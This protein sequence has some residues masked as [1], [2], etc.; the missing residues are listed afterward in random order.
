MIK[1]TY[2][3]TRKNVAKVFLGILTTCAVLT[4]FA[5]PIDSHTT[6]GNDEPTT[7]ME[8]VECSH[9]PETGIIT[10]IAYSDYGCL[11]TV[12]VANG[13]QFQ[14]Y[15]EGNA[16]Y[17]LYDII[18]MEMDSMGTELVTDDEIL[19]VKYSGFIELFMEYIK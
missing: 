8:I 7:E 15:S 5:Q 1:R 17:L 11:F 18:S 3:K 10:E 13:N 12:T 4:M 6:K 16:D 14:Y 9:Y 19:E 2:S